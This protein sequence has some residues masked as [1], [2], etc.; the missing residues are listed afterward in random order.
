MSTS[1]KVTISQ[2]RKAVRD[3]IQN[4]KNELHLKVIVEM[5]DPNYCRLRAIEEAAHPQPDHDLIITLFALAKVLSDED[6]D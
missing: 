4:P 1:K 5:D 2:L 6:V 3:S